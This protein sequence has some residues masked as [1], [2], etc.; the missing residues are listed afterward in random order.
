MNEEEVSVELFRAATS[1][2]AVEVLSWQ[3]V[4]GKN[5]FAFDIKL[6]LSTNERIEP[7]LVLRT[8]RAVWLIEVKGTHAEAVEDESK[9]VSL[10]E[11][12]GEEEILGQVYRRAAMD[13]A[14]P[15]PLLLSVAF[16]ENGPLATAACEPLVHH[17]CWADLHERVASEGLATVLEDVSGGRG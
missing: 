12:L 7:D 16:Y 17:L 1:D 6:R 15:R 14:E 11:D 3:S 13:E 4:N 9:L 10:V 5:Y 2:D 8:S